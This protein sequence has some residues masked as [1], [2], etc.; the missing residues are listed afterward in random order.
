MRTQ[1]AQE[2]ETG[3]GEQL[4]RGCYMNIVLTGFMGAGKS[5]IGRL[6]AEKLG[7]G[8]VDTDVYIEENAGRSIPEIFEKEG[9]GGFRE[10]ERETA[11]DLRFA[12]NLVIAAGGGFD[13]KPFKRDEHIKVVYIKRRVEDILPKLTAEKT[14]RPNADGRSPEE[15]I[16]LFRIR[17][18]GYEENAD[19]VLD[20]TKSEISPEDACK[21]LISLLK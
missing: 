20:M 15:I 2:H 19:I 3:T 21:N 8:F 4:K 12:D 14:G 13:V 5:T 18:P 17:E 16:K 9:E 11:Q 7:Y 6:L 10:Y 1:F